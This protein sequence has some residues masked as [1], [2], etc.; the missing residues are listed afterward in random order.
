FFVVDHFKG[1]PHQ[2]D[3]PDV[4]AGQLKQVFLSN[5][6]PLRQWI[7]TIEAPSLEASKLFPDYGIDFLYLDASHE[8][9]DVRSDLA[10]WLP[11]MKAGATIAGD[12]FSC[13]GVSRAVEETFGSHYSVFGRDKNR[14]WVARL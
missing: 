11:K 8:Y 1:S 14:I 12:D 2:A 6:R 3:D 7:T 4:A 10:A 5:T 9:E 13:E